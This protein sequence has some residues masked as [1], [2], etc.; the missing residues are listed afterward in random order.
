MGLEGGKPAALPGVQPE[1]FYKGNGLIL[2]ETLE[3]V[4]HFAQRR[5]NAP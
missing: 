3:R 2:Q 4:E 1:W 5:Q